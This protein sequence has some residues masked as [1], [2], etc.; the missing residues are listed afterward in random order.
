[1]ASKASSAGEDEL[2]SMITDRIFLNIFAPATDPYHNSVNAS[3]YDRGNQAHAFCT[4]GLASIEVPAQQL[5]DACT[6]RLTVRA[7]QRWQ[8][9]PQ[10][11][12]DA[13]LDRLGLTWPRLRRALLAE[14]DGEAERDGAIEDR[15]R[16]GAAE[17]DAAAARSAAE[18]RLKLDEW[19]ARFTGEG[20]VTAS[21]RGNQ[22]RLVE[23]VYDR[24]KSY[25]GDVLPNVYE[26]SQPLK[27]VVSA[28]IA[29]LQDLR[30]MGER[31]SEDAKRST[32]QALRA[33]EDAKKAPLLRRK[34]A[35]R[36]A[37]SQLNAALHDELDARLDEVLVGVLR[38]TTVK[39]RPEAGLV[40]RLNRV[41]KQVSDRLRVL[42]GR[43]T[44]L[45]KQ[46]DEKAVRLAR[47]VPPI[48]GL[49]IYEPGKSVDMEYRRCLLTH[50]G[51]PTGSLDEA[52]TFAAE[53]VI[54]AWNGLVDMVLPA[55]LTPRE[56]DVLLRGFDP[57]V[58]KALPEHQLSALH[59]A[60]SEPF[61]DLARINVLERWAKM[62][63]DQSGATPE[64]RARS[65]AQ[66]AKPFL[67]VDEAQVMEGAGSPLHMSS[68]MLLPAGAAGEADSF[69]NA[70]TSV[71]VQKRNSGAFSPHRYRAVLLS[72]T[73]RFPLRG[74][75]DVLGQGGLQDA[76]CNDFPTFHT[77]RD[78]HWLGLTRQDADRLRGAEELLVLSVLLGHIEMKS[79]FLTFSMNNSFGEAETRH[80]PMDFHAA[81]NMLAVEHLDARSAKL[82]GATSVLKSRVNATWQ[83]STSSPEAASEHFVRLLIDKLDAFYAMYPKPPIIAWGDKD[84][85]RDRIGAY[86]SRSFDLFSAY[87]RVVHL[88]PAV[89]ARLYLE[90]DGVGEWG[91]RVTEAGFYCPRDGGL[92][93]YT[94]QEAA[95]HGWRCM[96]DSD[97]HYGPGTP[98]SKV[99]A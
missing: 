56:E 19:R 13:V 85:A 70:I 82:N 68:L 81:A 9:A 5:T 35:Q 2:R 20:G 95:Q 78:V 54:S 30:E 11:D 93:G 14:S 49:S 51:D 63:V 4:F 84:W 99:F 86:M 97:H 7:L 39:G 34:A 69:K 80:L 91:G 45:I 62:G 8:N 98:L 57:N 73:Y 24:L 16:D 38:S 3:V 15:L 96:I 92:I 83:K 72:E 94:E 88:D 52:Q 40:E 64:A 89:R 6:S 29:W 36:E 27:Q 55:L 42:D 47:E 71:F 65:A 61:A 87:Q 67:K 31:S 58:D 10:T 18:A 43:V 33:L 75:T 66:L 50:N 23:T 22:N 76:Q 53:A 60:A 26:G 46:E 1:M 37:L 48:V 59:Q 12:T 25:A 17:I 44:Q 28:G 74:L 90:A 77:R 32:D 21:V 41:L 79:G